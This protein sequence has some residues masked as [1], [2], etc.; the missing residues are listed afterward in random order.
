MSSRRWLSSITPLLAIALAAGCGDNIDVSSG[1]ELVISPE[2]GLHTTE[3]GGTDTFTVAL[4]VAPRSDVT[5]EVASL[6]PAEGTASP[7]RITFTTANFALPVTVTVTGVDDTEDDGDQTFSV[8]LAATD[9][10][11]GSANREVAVINEDNDG[12][13]VTVAPT[14]ELMTTESGG[15]ATFT[16]V[17]DAQPTADVTIPVASNTTTEGTVDVASLT[18]TAVNWNAPQTVTVTGVDDAIADGSQSYTILLGSATSADP[19][20]QDLDPTDV[21][22][23]NVDNDS[24]GILVTP[25]TGL[26]TTEA[27]GTATFSVVL[28]S[29]PT[30]DVAIALSSSDPGEGTPGAA[31]LTFTS[32]NWDAPQVVTVTGI[33]DAL[34][35]GDQS[36]TI[37]LAPATS[38]DPGYVG[39]DGADVAVTNTDDEAPGFIVTP[40]SGLVTSEAGG[41]ATF[42]VALIS[43]PIANVTVAVTS[44]NPAEGTPSVAT[45]TF[46]PADF[47]TARTVTVTG[48]DDAVADG[49]QPYQIVLAPA[50]S[51]DPAYNGFDPP[52]VSVT[53]TDNDSPGITVT[54]LTGLLVSELGD[55]ATFT[56][57]LNSQPT[58]NVSIGIA[59]SDPSEGRVAPTNL[60]FTSANWD[61]PQT[62]TV[63][64]VDDAIADG[65]QVFQI[66]TAPAVS[67]DPRYSGLNAPNPTVTCFDDDIA[68]IVVR[69]QPIIQVSESGTSATF[70]I[71]LTSQP[72]ANVRCSVSSS[73]PNEGTV[74]PL[75]TIFTPAD[76]ALDHA[77][78]V[79]GVDDTVVDGNQLFVIVTAACT[80]TDPAYNN[81]NPR[82][83]NARN[84]DND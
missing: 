41:T 58:A 16:V 1:M 34:D 57:V 26:V 59:T 70:S 69:S 55:T 14:R 12:V 62:V 80:S 63:T 61:V 15:S 60:V 44:S 19:A 36:Y 75:F 25:T 18:F 35:D 6:D 53:N 54:P 38:G 71:I 42:T 49:N 78:T 76:F 51:T 27:G 82:D 45:L 7:S 13:G 10:D 22:V 20:Y 48:V 46:T 24:P 23:T 32:A 39:L 81:V 50:T 5:V 37:V 72:T 3:S 9:R 79:T 28:A 56:V 77:F 73:N 68:A 8:R 29:Q 74:S 40:T 67:A 2:T 47:A 33:D 31:S 65:N 83:V 21:S 52:D 30:A 66:G 64:G 17:L 43:A 11:G 4:A 84:L